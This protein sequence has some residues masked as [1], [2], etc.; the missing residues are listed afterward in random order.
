MFAIGFPLG[1]EGRSGGVLWVPHLVLSGVL[2]GLMGRS[3]R[4]LESSGTENLG[5]KTSWQVL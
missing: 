1:L 3:V 4:D 5:L 2:S